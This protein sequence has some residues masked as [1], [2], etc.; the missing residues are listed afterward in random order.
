[1]ACCPGFPVEHERIA[2]NDP[3]RAYEEHQESGSFIFSTACRRKY[4]GLWE[5]RDGY[6]Y[7]LKLRGKYHVIGDE[8][9]LASWFSGTLRVP[10]GALINYRH[11]GFSS[12]YEENIYLEIKDGK[13]LGQRVVDAEEEKACQPFSWRK[14]NAV[15]ILRSLFECIREWLDVDRSIMLLL[16]LIWLPIL[17]QYVLSD[18]WI[19]VLS[20]IGYAIYCVGLYTGWNS[21]LF[22]SIPLA[23]LSVVLILLG[24]ALIQLGGFT[25][26]RVFG[27]DIYLPHAGIGLAVL[28]RAREAWSKHHSRKYF[29][30][31]GNAFLD[32]YEYELKI[33]QE[34]KRKASQAN[35]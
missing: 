26:L 4:Q 32:D 16:N 25:A 2:L 7:L 1:M 28:G 22:N 9:I 17:L 35:D 27:V 33:M 19:G 31:H 12:E 14:I 6:L 8:P 30:K 34:A 3:A 13:L 23:R 24:I 18:R 29:E 21:I 5:I 11:S 20:I 10:Q 15:A